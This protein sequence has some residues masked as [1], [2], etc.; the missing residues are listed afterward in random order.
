MKRILAFVL[1][2]ILVV[3]PI[4]VSA[5]EFGDNSKSENASEE[6]MAVSE[7]AVTSQL[8]YTPRLS[9]PSRSNDYYYSNK[10]IFY[11][12]GYGMPNCTA[13]AWGRAYELLGTSPKLS[14]D[15][16]C[17]WWGYNQEH[18][19]YPTGQTPKLGAIAC[20]DNPYGGHVAV[21]EKITDTT[22][23]L[24]HS[25]WAGRT[26]FLTEFDKSSKTAGVVTSGWKF[27]GYIYILDG[28]ILPDGDVYRVDS[29]NGVNMRKGPGTSYNTLTA[30]PDKTEIVVTETKKAGGYT[31]GKTT[32]SGFE[33]WC[34]LDFCQLVQKR[35]DVVT[36]PQ[37][38][39]SQPPQED[40][41]SEDLPAPPMLSPAPKPDEDVNIPELS[42]PD[43]STPSTWDEP[44]ISSPDES[45][46]PDVNGDGKLTVSDATAL[47]KHLAGIEVSINLEKADVN[48]DGKVSVSDAT[49]IQ[50]IIAGIKIQS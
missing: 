7:T 41:P 26:F 16:A 3:V 17:F 42:S 2:M 15:S 44:E 50:K 11:S 12:I 32:F 31:W 18:N 30:I 19:Y 43:E 13:Y 38:L 33:G 8:K 36:P 39:P 28:E 37:E 21:V 40:L 24:S 47:Q 29:S 45:E 20:W 48:R 4:S 14:V 22:V 46:L 34:V 27:E 9:A 10:N 5:G 25:E 23:T 49:Y 1:M 35:P 6:V